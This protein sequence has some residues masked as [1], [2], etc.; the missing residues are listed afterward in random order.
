MAITGVTSARAGAVSA[1]LQ[2]LLSRKVGLASSQTEVATTTDPLGPAVLLESSNNLR[3]DGLYNSLGQLLIANQPA[4]AIA[5]GTTEAE[6]QSLAITAAAER[7]SGGDLSGGRADAEEILKDDPKN[8]EAV[9][10]VA[11]TYL[12][13]GDYR[14]AE[15]MYSRAA[16]LVPDNAGY[17]DDVRIAQSLQSSDE[18]VLA[19]ARREMTNPATR[20]RALR[21]LGQLTGRSPDSLDAYLALADGFTLA[22]KPESVFA[23]LAGAAERAGDSRIDEVASRARDVA[24][25]LP[26]AASVHNLLGRVLLQTG[27]L[28]EGITELTQAADLDPYKLSFGTDL[29][30]GYATRSLSRLESG[31]LSGARMD[32]TAAKVIAPT[33]PV[34]AEATARVAV[35]EARRDIAT[36]RYS[37]ALGKLSIAYYKRPG[38]AEFAEKLAAL[39]TGLGTHLEGRSD[40][41]LAL[42]AFAKAYALDPSSTVARKKVAELSFSLGV[43]AVDAKDYDKAITMLEQAY[44][45]YRLSSDYGQALANAYDLRG[46]LRVS[47]DELDLAIEDFKRGSSVDPTNTS[48]SA[49]YAAAVNQKNES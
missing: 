1:T 9:R 16:A 24:A 28:D 2:A 15:Q 39:Y 10:L 29:A 47:L 4:I 22:Q 6:T 38:D 30:V 37:S 21:L 40:D 3:S 20:N 27:D 23:A 36:Q 33:D 46:Q 11:V 8:I 44:E 13:E 35:Y 41:A 49:H 45:T 34:V 43:E 25:R 14:Q 7:I 31:D 26:Q 19:V 17:Q 5:E 18:E 32:V 12:L 42:S 48:L